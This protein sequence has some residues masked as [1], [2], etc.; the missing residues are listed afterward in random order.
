MP[1]MNVLAYSTDSSSVSVTSEI[2][3]DGV[4]LS[5]SEVPTRVEQVVVPATTFTRLYH[6][7]CFAITPATFTGP[8]S[9]P[10]RPVGSSRG[11]PLAL[12]GAAGVIRWSQQ[13]D[14]RDVTASAG[15]ER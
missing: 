3:T 1:T 6:A 12:R 5:R 14:A 7:P 15:V 2:I 4:T 9:W 13:T 10:P 11:T 8:V